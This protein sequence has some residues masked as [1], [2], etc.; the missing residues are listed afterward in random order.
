[1]TVR[2]NSNVNVTRSLDRRIGTSHGI[3]VPTRR[4]PIPDGKLRSR[5]DL[6]QHVDK[7][8]AWSLVS[9]VQGT[10]PA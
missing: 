9:G 10:A 3:Q 4:S 1:V 2:H 7:M 5:L 6:G 8:H